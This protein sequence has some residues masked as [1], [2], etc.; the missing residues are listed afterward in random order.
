MDLSFVHL[1]W[2]WGD[3]EQAPAPTP[4]DGRR[5]SQTDISPCLRV[6]GTPETYVE[7]ASVEAGMEGRKEEWIEEGTVTQT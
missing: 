3:A 2:G 5:C 1:C 6:R 4:H 7:M